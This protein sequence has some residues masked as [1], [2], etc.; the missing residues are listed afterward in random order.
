MQTLLF[1]SLR[2]LFDVSRHIKPAA[3]VTNQLNTSGDY[4]P[5]LQFRNITA[6]CD[7]LDEQAIKGKHKIATAS[8]TVILGFIFGPPP[9]HYSYII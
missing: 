9:F 5:L 7:W 8:S 2:S 1:S 4:L 3:L 6:Y